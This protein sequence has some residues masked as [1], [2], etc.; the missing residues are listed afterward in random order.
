LKKEII[1]GSFLDAFYLP[2]DK[3]INLIEQI[4]KTIKGI[5][6]ERQIQFFKNVKQDII[7]NEYGMLD[8]KFGLNKDKNFRIIN[9][10]DIVPPLDSNI[11]FIDRIL[12]WLQNRKK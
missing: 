7:E 10:I 3:E 4:F 12:E 11:T 1:T 6:L 9:P 8:L 2:Q 5:N